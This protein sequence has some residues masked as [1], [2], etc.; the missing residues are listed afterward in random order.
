MDKCKLISILA[1][2]LA[3]CGGGGGGKGGGG[4]APAAS[5]TTSA[6]SAD[7][8]SVATADAV[9]RSSPLSGCSV[10]QK[11]GSTPD[12]GLEIR[13]IYWI[14]VVQQ[15]MDDPATRLAANKQ[16]IVRV[17]VTGP[18]QTPL[19]AQARLMIGSSDGCRE[20][21]L[22]SGS[23]LAPATVDPR[24]LAASYTATIPASDINERLRSYQLVVDPD[25]SASRAV[26]DRLY[27]AGTLNVL[28]AMSER[29]IIRPITFGGRTG[30]LPDTS[31]LGKLLGRA[32]PQ[33]SLH[34]AQGTDFTPRDLDPATA[35][36]VRGSGPDTV[37]RFTFEQMVSV[38]NE[39]DAACYRMEPFVSL[40][41]AIKCV[42]AFPSNVEFSDPTRTGIISGL[43]INQAF[44]MASFLAIENTSKTSPYEG[45]WLTNL[46][47]LFV[48][49]FMHLMLLE[50]ANCGNPGKLDGRLYPDGSIGPQ[51]AGHDIERGFYFANTDGRFSDFMSY[52]FYS[53]WTSDRAYRIVM[54]FKRTA[55]TTSTT[56]AGGTTEPDT[57]P[58]SP[59]SRLIRLSRYGG[60]WHAMSSPRTPGLTR[61]E[62][63]R[64]A[65]FI[66]PELAGQPVWAPSSHFGQ[67]PHGPMYIPENSEVMAALT[68]G[69]MK[70]VRYE[71]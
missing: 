28:P 19:P 11:L 9:T 30:V 36:S 18:G 51:G 12:T 34:V 1:I 14:Q 59:P 50:H 27:R 67:L 3:A 17:D 40:P 70:N 45:G 64:D 10:T 47:E 60:Y 21:T 48:H 35:W 49:E 54:E 39:L 8:Y 71:P 57:S 61:L 32:L 66:D 69:R 15:A 25:G 37:Y 43:A 53:R 29:I 7:T 13:G 33:S 44:I 38:L 63:G 65:G 58:D 41:A 16:V 46:A 52:C 62:G 24:T 20:Y 4:R 56:P 68:S 55:A 42:A 2:V 5:Q 23:P 26:A 22:A 31:S 6:Q